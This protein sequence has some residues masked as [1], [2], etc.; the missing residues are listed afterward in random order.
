V[1]GALSSHWRAGDETVTTHLRLEAGR[2][3]GR[4]ERGDETA[5]VDCV[6]HRAGPQA[7]VVRWGGRAWRAAIVRRGTTTWVAVEGH[8]FELEAH[9]G[10]AEAVGTASEPFATIPMTGVLAKVNV[11]PGDEV[12]AGSEL[13]VV[14]AMKMEF[15]VKAPRDVTIRTVTGSAGDA[16]ALGD[17][18]VTFVESA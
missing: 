15:S 5:D 13:F 17:A 12:A 4:L 3:V 9:A 2:L 1:S 14:E 16:V 11:A 7:V 6:V 8:A 18:V 10:T